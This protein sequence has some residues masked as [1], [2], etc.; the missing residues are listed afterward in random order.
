MDL[1]AGTRWSAPPLHPRAVEGVVDVWRA[2]LEQSCSRG[3]LLAIVSRYVGKSPEKLRLEEGTSGKPQ[4]DATNA[5]GLAEGLKFNMTHSKGLTLV[6]VTSQREVGID[7]EVASGSRK[8]RLEEVAIA[9]RLLGE[10]RAEML[11]G[12]EGEERRMELLRAWT[13]HEA[14]VKCLGV[15]L[16]GAPAA[17]DENAELWTEEL[18]VGIGAVAAV[19]VAG[20]ERCEV[21]RWRWPA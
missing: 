8:R 1:A 7:V 9:K 3:R 5:R 12:M 18:D 14:R 4:L 11:E 19:A 13:R 6:A 21:R 16:G 20:R 2:D 17:A 10:E 15:G